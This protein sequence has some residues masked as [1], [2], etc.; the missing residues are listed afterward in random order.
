LFCEGQVNIGVWLRDLGLE[1]YADSFKAN[2]IDHEMLSKLTEAGLGT[3]GILLSHRK[4]PTLPA[5]AGTLPSAMRPEAERQLTMLFCGLVGSSE[6]AARLDPEDMGAI[7]R[8][9]HRYCAKMV[10][11]SVLTSTGPRDSLHLAF[12]AMLASRWMRG[13]FPEW[14]G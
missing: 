13:L 5:D 2:A 3:L 12:P 7:T 6:L 9:H 14:A 4:K 8:T 11:R 10:E 1:G